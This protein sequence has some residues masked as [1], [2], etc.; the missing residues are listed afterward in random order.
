MFIDHGKVGGVDLNDR[1]I[2]GM[3]DRLEGTPKVVNLGR[4]RASPELE[5]RNGTC[6][7]HTMCSIA[8]SVRVYGTR[9]LRQAGSSSGLFL[10]TGV[11]RR[12]VSPWL[13]LPNALPL[14]M[15]PRSGSP[16]WRTRPRVKSGSWAASQIIAG[17]QG[18]AVCRC[19]H[20]SGASVSHPGV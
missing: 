15:S 20:I 8:Y 2:P 10:Y 5:S 17:K 18:F 1:V 14:S 9:P 16:D 13:S 6:V 11:T 19:G 7:A 4:I 12:R 3:H